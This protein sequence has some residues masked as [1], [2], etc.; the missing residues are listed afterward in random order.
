[1]QITTN[2]ASLDAQRNYQRA[3]QAL[4][5][6]E[7]RLSSGQR[8]NSAS[9]DAAGLAISDRLSTQVTGLNRA[10]QNA[11]DGISLL[12]VADGGL[13]QIS[14]NF[15]RIRELA[16]QAGNSTN[17]T[18]DRQAIQQEAD[19]LTASSLDIANQT[20]FNQL[21]LLDGSYNTQLQVGANAGD[22]IAVAIPPV[23]KP[24]A[25]GSVQ[26][27]VPEQQVSIT[28]QVSGALAAGT[29]TVNQ[30]AVGASVAG[31][32]AGQSSA[33]A[34]AVAAA[35]NAAGVRGISVTANNSISTTL[36]G[37]GSVHS[38][39]IGGSNPAAAGFSAGAHQSSD[40]GNTVTV[41]RSAADGGE[42]AIDLSS[43]AGAT[44]A[45]T[46]IDSKIDSTNQI[47]AYLG[48]TENRLEQ[49]H[50]SALASAANLST[51]RGRIVDTDY[52]S[53]TAQMTRTKILQQAGASMVA[54]ANA[55]PQLA[56]ALLR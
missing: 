2:L 36:S 35:I 44:D 53:E 24:A 20:Q 48:A 12:Q 43:V 28:G 9:D 33:S 41:L 26:V 13:A 55:L 14:D 21:K 37:G 29:L 3:G 6:S 25:S 38:V 52:A 19:A 31:P 54:Q 56:L 16:V 46:Y 23:F 17:S 7:Q 47:R 34:Y 39:L 42:P 8:I 51:A 4:E 11:N 15:Q 5:L 30:T 22:T 49:V 1:M 10:A 40:T 45:L 18:S 32:S 27:D 50:S